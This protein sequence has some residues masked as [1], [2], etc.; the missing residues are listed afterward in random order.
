MHPTY[1]SGSQDAR[2]TC[3]YC[4]G[5]IASDPLCIDCSYHETFRRQQ[6]NVGPLLPSRD[7]T[8]RRSSDD[9][10]CMSGSG[11]CR[12]LQSAEKLLQLLANQVSCC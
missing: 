9:D 3:L 8:F 11:L 4:C 7:I 12:M 5:D 6:S 10:D 2:Y 1:P